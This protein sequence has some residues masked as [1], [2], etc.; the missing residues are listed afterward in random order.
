MMIVQASGRR[1]RGLTVL[2]PNFI[3]DAV[4]TFTA[5]DG[6][7][8]LEVVGV[9]TVCERQ[10]RKSASA[11]YPLTQLRGVKENDVDRVYIVQ[12]D[13]LTAAGGGAATT[14]KTYEIIL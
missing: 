12:L 2:D 11:T 8:W 14:R 13:H 6:I 10:K 7:L 3:Q 4:T 1:G 5:A 9:T